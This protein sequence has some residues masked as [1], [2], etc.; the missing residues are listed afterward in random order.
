MAVNT[1][2]GVRTTDTGS[3][4]IT[5]QEA[6]LHSAIDYS[7]YDSLIPTYIT[8]SR[9]MIEGTSGWAL[10]EKTVTVDLSIDNQLPF[11]LPFNPIKEVLS[12]INLTNGHCGWEMQMMGD[13]QYI[14]FTDPGF[15]RVEYKAGFTV[16]PAEF[17]LACLQMF[18]FYFTN[19]GEDM[20]GKSMISAE[21]E[22]II[23]SL[24]KFG[25]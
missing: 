4:P 7:D 17:K 12:V 18:A 2:L 23:E 20:S 13:T 14:R 24:R 8:A 1:I 5:M 22:R 16:L 25:V 9:R 6:K 10:V 15:Y 21:A 3:E 19:R 11:M